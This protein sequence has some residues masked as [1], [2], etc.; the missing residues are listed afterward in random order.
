MP[1]PPPRRRVDSLHSKVQL[2][3]LGRRVTPADG[4]LYLVFENYAAPS[5]RTYDPAFLEEY[6]RLYP[7]LKVPVT[8]PEQILE[9]GVY[10]PSSSRLYRYVRAFCKDPE[11]AAKYRIMC[12]R[13]VKSPKPKKVRLPKPPKPKKIK[14]GGYVPVARIP[15][16]RAAQVEAFK[17]E[18]YDF[19]D[20][21]N[22]IENLL[23]GVY[24]RHFKAPTT[25]EYMYRVL[26]GRTD[27]KFREVAGRWLTKDLILRMVTGGSGSS[28]CLCELQKVRF[29]LTWPELH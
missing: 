7:K 9:D 20:L 19:Q 10:I 27:P 22:V 24:E 28:M 5:K 25:L 21:V 3:S 2:L 15:F 26:L 12:P 1:T 16:L 8:T 18:H 29:G 17:A 13:P 11:F 23:V 14:K 6:N 4:K